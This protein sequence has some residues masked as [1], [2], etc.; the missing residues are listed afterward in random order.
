[1]VESFTSESTLPSKGVL[2]FSSQLSPSF[3]RILGAS[4][5][6]VPSTTSIRATFLYNTWKALL[7]PALMGS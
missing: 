7:D 1:M 5:H 3:T 2:S 4:S 6:R